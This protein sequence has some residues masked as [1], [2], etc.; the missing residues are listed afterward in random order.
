M[1]GR[2][3]S[4]TA[5]A[6]STR[7]EG[8]RG[9]GPRQR[10]SARPGSTERPS[11]ADAPTPLRARLSNRAATDADL[12]GILT[13]LGSAFAPYRARYTRRAYAATVLDP[14]RG[15]RRLRAMAVW[16]AVDRTGQVVATVAARRVARD[17]AHLRGMAVAPSH[18]RA[19]VGGRLI[20]RVLRELQG[21]EP[22]VVT[23]ETTAPLADARRFY[24]RHGFAPTGRRR[25]WGGMELTEFA[26]RLEPLRSLRRR[27]SG[28]P[29]SRGD[30]ARS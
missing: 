17:H 3:D 1:T 22:V 21:P 15:R 13:C 29:P 11:R 12:D 23:L 8:R 19:G 14:A 20:R 26:R 9:A 27:S 18:Q 6:A 16:V 28:P 24:A 30:P 5:R 2:S 25:R 10:P 4:A 7:G